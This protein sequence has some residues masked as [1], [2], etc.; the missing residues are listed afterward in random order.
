MAIRITGTGAYIPTERIT[1]ADFAKHEF[2]NEDGS[3]FPYTNDVVAQK[4]EDI[5]GIQERRY[6]SN[7]LLTSDIATLAARQA[8]AESGIDPETLDYVILAHNFG[9]VRADAIQTDI[10]PSLA[11]RVK[12]ALGI[13]NPR[14]VAYDILF[15]CPGWIEGVI[16][17]QAFIR[18]GM[19]RRCLVIGAETLS[20][21]LDPHDRDSMIYSDGAGAAVVEWTQGEGGILTHAT[22]SYTADE[23]YF[24]FFGGSFNKKL[25]PNTRFIKMHGR[26]IYE[27]AVSS[28]P[29]AMQICL[30]QS[31][32]PIDEVKKVIIH[33]ANEKMD[34]AIIHRFFKRYGRV[35]PAGV[36]PMSIHKLGNSSVATVPTLFHMLL[37]K[38]I[39]GQSIAAGDV[40]LFASVGAGMNI[41]AFVYRV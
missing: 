16:Q 2:L 4:F 20:R 12:H 41:N 23:A 33:Q 1:N 21:V 5:T 22:L 39:K 17:A 34:E 28:V 24:L 25:D 11:S 27:F 31:G 10:L 15:G 37:H 26:K 18:A 40:L 8:I 13:K 29:E 19:A 30:D 9:D 36:M 6:A 35:A 7:H 3:P 38:Q 14:C 32:I